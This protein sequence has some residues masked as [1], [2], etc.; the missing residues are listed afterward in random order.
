MKLETPLLIKAAYLGNVKIFQLLL[1]HGCDV[2]VQGYICDDGRNT[3]ETNV[4][5][6][7]VTSVETLIYPALIKQSFQP[8]Q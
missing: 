2:N 5:G 3:Y 4:L 6:A 8:K 7:A 1:A